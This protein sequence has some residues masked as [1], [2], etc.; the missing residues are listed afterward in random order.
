M[1][2]CGYFK[3]VSFCPVNFLGH[4]DS[5]VIKKVFIAFEL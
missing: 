3:V 2:N 5:Y 4:C 1:E